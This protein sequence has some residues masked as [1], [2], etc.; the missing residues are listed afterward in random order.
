MAVVCAEKNWAEPGEWQDGQLKNQEKPQQPQLQ[1]HKP[2]TAQKMSE[3]FTLILKLVRI[4]LDKE[5]K[6][7]NEESDE[8][9]I[10]DSLVPSTERRTR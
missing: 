6:R 1:D 9:Q 10:S 7:M 5:D 2:D 8:D 4:K 3:F